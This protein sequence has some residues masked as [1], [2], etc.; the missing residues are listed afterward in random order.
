[1]TREETKK[2]MAALRVSYPMYYQGLGREE[3]SKAKK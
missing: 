2:I 3:L 1:M